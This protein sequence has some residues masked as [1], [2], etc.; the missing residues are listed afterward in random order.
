MGLARN[1]QSTSHT[2][3]QKAK[4]AGSVGLF[5][6]FKNHTIQW[7]PNSPKSCVHF[8]VHT[9]MNTLSLLQSHSVTLQGGKGQTQ[10][11]AGF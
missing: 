11:A 1:K 7:P 2:K 6:Q 5:M 3:I 9:G 8:E 4:Y 10:P